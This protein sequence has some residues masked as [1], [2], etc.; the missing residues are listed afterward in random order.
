MRGLRG[1]ELLEGERV[2]RLVRAHPL[3]RLADFGPG[4]ALLAFAAVLAGLA[5]LPGAPVRAVAK[6]LDA[7]AG[8]LAVP[9]LLVPWWLGLAGCAAPFALARRAA[10][11]LAYGVGLAVAGGFAAILLGLPDPSAALAAS[12]LPWLTLAGAPGALAIAEARRRE[13]TWV[14]TSLRLVR[15]QGLVRRREEGWRLPRLERVEVE[16]RGPRVLGIGD[17]VVR[18]AGGIELRVEGVRPLLALRDQVELLLQTSPAP[19]YLREQR[20]L[21]ERVTQLLR[22]G[23]APPR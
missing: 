12:L 14:L 13:P 5:A 8:P 21:V 16:R 17:L 3:A 10:W 18:G 15:L 1:L 7:G 6:L 11:P 23:S 20:D 4:L 19:A 9:L 22:P 2:M